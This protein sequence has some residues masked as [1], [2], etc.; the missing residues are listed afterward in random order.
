MEQTLKS[1]R[2]LYTQY[3]NIPNVGKKIESKVD[4]DDDE[5]SLDEQEANIKLDLESQLAS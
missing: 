1:L 3:M 5:P 4:V 2:V